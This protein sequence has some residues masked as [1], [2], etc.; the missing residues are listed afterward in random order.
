MF[1]GRENFFEVVGGRFAQGM[2]MQT[3]NAFRQSVGKV[4]A[5]YAEARAG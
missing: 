3:F 4:F 1:E 2:E 5:A